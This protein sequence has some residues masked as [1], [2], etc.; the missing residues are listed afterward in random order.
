MDTGPSGSSGSSSADPVR[1]LVAALQAA[2]PTAAA[3]PTPPAVTGSPMALPGTFSGEAAE[4][5]GFLLQVN[6]YIEMQPQRFPS[7][8]SKVAFFISLLSGRALAWA[9]SLW[10]SASPVLNAYALFTAH[11]LEVFSAAS[12]VLTTADQLL[13]LRQG[14]DDITAYSLRFRTLAA[15]S[16]WN[17]SAL[18]SIYRVGLSPEIKQAMAIYDDR[19]GLEEFIGKSIGLS[20]R[21]AACPPIHH[22]SGTHP[23][24]TPASDTEPMQLGSQRLSRRERNSRL[25]TGKCLYCG[26]PGHSIARCTR[27]PVR[28]AD[29]EDEGLLVSAQTVR[30]TLQ[31][32]CLHGRCQKRKPFLKLTHKNACKQF[33]EELREPCPKV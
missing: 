27:R 4:C 11:F 33:A 13:S 23:A 21:L 12:G 10:D 15:S 18:L 28:T 16:G 24:T 8:R 26:D 1:D 2:F 5:R 19:M 30:R 3:R 20:Q 29:A 25:A 17:E 31:Q 6:L 14:S 32:V 9:Q 7:E 22:P